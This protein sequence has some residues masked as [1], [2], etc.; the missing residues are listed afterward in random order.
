MNRPGS[1][2][3]SYSEAVA[4]KQQQREK[5]IEKKYHSMIGMPE[6]R[7][8]GLALTKAR[9]EQMWRD[10]RLDQTMVKTRRAKIEAHGLTIIFI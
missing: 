7:I 1:R 4:E 2:H 6:K 10:R 3:Q 9:E 5:N 8:E